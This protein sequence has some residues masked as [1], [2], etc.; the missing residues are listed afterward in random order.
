MAPA[1]PAASTVAAATPAAASG[2]TAFVPELP[3]PPAPGTKYPKPTIGDKECWQRV[4]LSGAAQKDFDTIVGACGNPTGM[5]EYAQPARGELTTEHHTDMFTIKLYGGM[6]YRFVAAADQ[7]VPDLDIRIE[8]M[9]GALVA[10]DKTE[11]PIAIIES[12]KPW[13]APEDVE[14]RIHLTLDGKGRGKYVF[15]VWA[16]PGK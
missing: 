3:K 13:C 9:N 4:S 12:D 15:G 11:Q 10:I 6:C 8:K 7:G 1:S 2:P 16:R 14:Y 5:L